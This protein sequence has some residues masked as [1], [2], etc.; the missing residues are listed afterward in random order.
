MSSVTLAA[1]A[2]LFLLASNYSPASMRNY[3]IFLQRTLTCFVAADRPVQQVTYEDLVRFLAYCEQDRAV[4]C[5]TLRHYTTILKT[6][7][8]WCVDVGYIERNPAQALKSPRCPDQRLVLGVPVDHLRRMLDYTEQAN[9]RNYA[10]LLFMAVTGCRVSATSALRLDRLDISRGRASTYEKGGRWVVYEFDSLTAV[11]LSDWLALRPNVDHPYVWTGPG[12]D[13]V[14]L[15]ATGIRKMLHDLCKRLDLPHY[16]PHQLR[17]SAGEI[18]AA[19]DHS[20]LSVASALN[21]KN[22]QSARI[23]MPKRLP[24]TR[25]L[26]REIEATLYPDRSD[27]HTE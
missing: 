8:G 26:R 12:P 15:K 14:Q 4:V 20:E 9:R 13:Y 21:H 2:D 6:F 19:N 22:P 11:A 23:Y 10:V 24:Q 18:L 25:H 5:L 17:H 27:L 7:F 16:T 1:A 3:R